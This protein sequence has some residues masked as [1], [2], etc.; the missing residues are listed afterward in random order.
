MKQDLNAKQGSTFLIR[1]IRKLIWLFRLK[2][3]RI[4]G[5]I[6]RTIIRRK[7][8]VV[9]YV[10][11]LERKKQQQSAGIIKR[12]A[13]KIIW[14]VRL[15][16][17]RTIEFIR[18][19][20]GQPLNSTYKELKIELWIKH[21][22]L[23][24]LLKHIYKYNTKDWSKKPIS[25]AIIIRDGATYPKSSAFIRLISPLSK[26]AADN[27]ISYK[28]FKENTTWL[29]HN[30]NICIVQRTAYDN[31][32]SAKRLLSVI[33]KR[34][35][36]L[37]IDNDDAFSLIDDT[38]SEYSIQGDRHKALEYLVK[39]A[40]QV[41]V[42]TQV[43]A[44]QHQINNDS[45]HVITNTLD[46]NLWETQ[47]PT[48]KIKGPL[49]MIYMGTATHDEDLK[50][51]INVLDKLASKFPGKF[52]LSVIG[53]SCKELPERNWIKR[54]Y[55][56]SGGAI[57]PKFVKWFVN[58]GPFDIGLCPLVESPFNNSKSDIKCLD[59]IGANILPIASNVP[60]YNTKGLD[61]YVVRID[62]NQDL[63]VN[64]FSEILKDIKGFRK[65]SKITLLKAKAYLWEKRSA[66]VA[67]QTILKLMKQK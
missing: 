17:Q 32:L 56:P 6:R 47:K 51:L 49:R 41:W 42:S 40:D 27:L 18:R 43:L 44:K 5:L 31:E 9:G 39:N 54:L 4:I 37:I 53:V 15:S 8:R 7:Q 48:R 64:K 34:N 25:V 55:Q 11:R 3:K 38:H 46:N 29:P 60:A 26:L 67:A 23:Q 61:D 28:I 19:A 21:Y 63:W 45:V 59:Y 2:K 50:M 14:L 66:E 20:T 35:A 58:Q 13:R 62:N 33:K 36:K 52:E 24:K 65:K 22:R 57:Y 16:K 10:Q 12:D 30:T 1:A